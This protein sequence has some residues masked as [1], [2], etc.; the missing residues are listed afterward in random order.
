M[1][2]IEQTKKKMQAALDHL[3]GD[4]RALRTNRANA[5]M[6][7]G[8]SV[9]VYGTRMRLKEMASI[10]VPEARQLII[11]PF[12]MSNLHSIARA[13]EAANLNI[14]PIVDGNVV[15]IKIPEMDASTRQ[16]IVKQAKKKAEEAKIAIRNIRREGNDIAKKQKT[17]SVITEDMFKKL[18][19]SIQELTDKFCKMADEA[20]SEKEKEI[21]TI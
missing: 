21:L 20:T 12:D 6:V 17:E 2:L 4:L 10:S 1:D 19:K 8:V 9:E 14:Q 13:I 7:D 18:E 16:E 11:T 5:A 15:R 3:K